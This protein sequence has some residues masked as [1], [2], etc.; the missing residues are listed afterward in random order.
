MS[1][2]ILVV[3]H[4]GDGRGVFQ[5]KANYSNIDVLTPEVDVQNQGNSR[6]PPKHVGPPIPE[7]HGL[8]GKYFWVPLTWV[9]GVPWSHHEGIDRSI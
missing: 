1:F 9:P 3:N 2:V 4:P 8:Y 7:S 5:P 6:E